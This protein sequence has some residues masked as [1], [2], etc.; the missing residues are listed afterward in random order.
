MGPMIAQEAPGVLTVEPTGAF[1]IGISLTL[2]LFAV[3]WLLFG[4]AT[5]R[6][7]VFPRGAGVLLSVGAALFLIL[8]MMELPLWTV[9]LSAAVAWMGYTISYGEAA[10]SEVVSKAT[11]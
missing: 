1:L 7:G 3:G 2:I 11:A 4:L 10:T 9:I 6:A 5:I 8:G